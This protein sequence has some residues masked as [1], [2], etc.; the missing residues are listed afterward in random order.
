MGP[1]KC[2]P[3]PA[4]HISELQSRLPIRVYDIRVVNISCIINHIFYY[5]GDGNYLLQ[6]L[7]YHQRRSNEVQNSTPS[8]V[9]AG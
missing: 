8:F 5:Y 9:R 6:G 2:T 7:H 4:I 3:R 1:F